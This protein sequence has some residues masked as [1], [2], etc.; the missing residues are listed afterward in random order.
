MGLQSRV[1][2]RLAPGKVEFV[3]I[4]YKI[5]DKEQR[6]RTDYSRGYEDL[7]WKILPK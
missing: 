5:D 3:S 2:P 6:R 4:C 7:T 1:A